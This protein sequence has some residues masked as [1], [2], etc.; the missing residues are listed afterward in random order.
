MKVKTSR[1]SGNVVLEMGP[2]DS[3]LPAT[4]IPDVQLKRLLVPVDFSDCSHKAFHYAVQFA[5]QFSAELMLLHVIVSVPPPPQLLVFDT[6]QM[7]NKYQEYAAKQLSAWRN[8]AV[9]T[10][11]VRAVTRVG[12]AAHR[13]IVEAARES[14]TDLIV[15]GNHGRTGLSRL[16]TGGTTERVVRYAPCPVLVIREREHD[17][18]REETQA[19][20]TE[21]PTLTRTE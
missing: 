2:A 20:Q 16:M 10:L 18:V 19:A 8:E 9:P 15:I 12:A 5:R 7:N 6:E 3:G 1:H 21:S 11:T 14:N 17:F 13:E 4:T